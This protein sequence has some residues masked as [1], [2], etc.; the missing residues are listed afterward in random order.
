MSYKLEIL[1]W[2]LVACYGSTE[3]KNFLTV[4][5]LVENIFVV[6]DERLT[7]A[8]PGEKGKIKYP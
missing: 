8:D 5:C 6:S 7:I 4:F 3:L 2:G 1:K